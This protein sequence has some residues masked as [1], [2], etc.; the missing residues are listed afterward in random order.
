MDLGSQSNQ[1]HLMF[2]PFGFL[3][4][5]ADTQTGSECGED[6][7]NVRPGSEQSGALS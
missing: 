4:S 3:G 6:T 1:V 7:S 2:P 5:L